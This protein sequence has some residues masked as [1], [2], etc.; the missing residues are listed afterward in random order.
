MRQA[1][2]C[3]LLALVWLISGVGAG[4]WIQAELHVPGVE[5]DLLSKKNF[6]DLAVPAHGAIL[7]VS[8]PFSACAAAGLAL[9]AEQRRSKIWAAGSAL[10]AALSF[11]AP[12]VLVGMPDIPPLAIFASVLVACAAGLFAA[13]LAAPRYRLFLL[14]IGAIGA[15]FIGLSLWA[16]LSPPM[17]EFELYETYAGVALEHLAGQV[18]VLWSFAVCFIW[19]S[20]DRSVHRVWPGVVLIVSA[21]LAMWLKA[22]SEI[23]LG[24]GGMPRGYI[25]YPAS[26]TQGQQVSGWAG[27]SLACVLTVAMGYL[28]FLK[29]RQ[30]APGA[31]DAF[32]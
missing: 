31:D 29:S 2:I 1:S 3:M 25:D 27:L 18:F 28:A 7:S 9:L 5:G 13:A 6:Y 32:Q 22:N 23:E 19:A 14:L 8:L 17:R 26:T 21:L 16:Y 4:L 30:P 24:L 10:L 20:G 12:M 11:F 15:A